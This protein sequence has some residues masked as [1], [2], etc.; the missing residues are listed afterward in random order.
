MA[1]RCEVGVIQSIHHAQKL[2]KGKATIIAEMRFVIVIIEALTDRIDVAR[3]YDEQK[4][5]LAEYGDGGWPV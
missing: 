4:G 3:L 2:S 5:L 1:C